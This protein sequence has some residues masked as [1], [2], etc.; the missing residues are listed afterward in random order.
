[1]AQAREI[2]KRIKSVESTKKITRTMELVSTSKMK[3]AQ[4]R[5]HASRP[6]ASKMREILGTLSK[7]MRGGDIDHPLLR[8]PQS[9]RRVAAFVITSNRGLCGAYNSNVLRLALQFHRENTAAG[10][11][12]AIYA[13]GKKAINYFNYRGIPVAKTMTEPAE[14]PVYAHAEQICAD[15]IRDFGAPADEAIDGASLIYTRFVS[16]GRLAPTVEALLPVTAEALAG[17]DEGND[18]PSDMMFEPDASEIVSSLM[19]L[20]V[21]MRVFE[22]LLNAQASEH[23]A[24]MIAMKTATDNADDLTKRLNRVYNRERQAQITQELA[25]ILGGVEALKG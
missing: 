18:G 6:Y 12:V 21:K 19:P 25:E 23:S 16:A 8:V 11:E 9:V 13:C 1:M 15:L 14:H 4:D 7:A 5:V 17:E 2:L 10:R 20:M 3:K 22:V 24:R